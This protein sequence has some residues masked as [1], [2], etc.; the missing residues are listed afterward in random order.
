MQCFCR[1]APQLRAPLRHHVRLRLKGGA[2]IGLF[3][4][5]RLYSPL[6]AAQEVEVN[7]EFTTTGDKTGS[8]DFHSKDA[9]RISSSK[10]A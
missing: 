2:V 1:A 10:A 8:R 3:Q 9:H 5:W 6:S 7:R 4:F